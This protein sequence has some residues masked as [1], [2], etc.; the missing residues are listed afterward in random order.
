MDVKERE[1]DG[2]IDGYIERQVDG[3]MGG[4]IGIYD[5]YL[6]IP[7]SYTGIYDS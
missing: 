5:I 3:W 1:R 7:I 2:Q 4:Q 6:Y